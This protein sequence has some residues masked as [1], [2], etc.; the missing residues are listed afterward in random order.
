[1]LLFLTLIAIPDKI[2]YADTEYKTVLNIR[3]IID[4]IYKTDDLLKEYRIKQ[5][6]NKN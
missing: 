3:K 6:T 4:Y 2:K 5:K 1:M